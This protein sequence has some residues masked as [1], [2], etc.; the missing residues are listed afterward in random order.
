MEHP[1]SATGRGGNPAR[2]DEEVV[3]GR[4][5][6][7][8]NT[9]T[10]PSLESR[11]VFSQ[12]HSAYSASAQPDSC[13]RAGRLP[14]PLMLLQ[15]HHRA[16]PILQ[17]EVI[18]PPPLRC[19]SPRHPR[20]N[21]TSIFAVLRQVLCAVLLFYICFR[22]LL[23]PSDFVFPWRAINFP[24]SPRLVPILHFSHVAAVAVVNAHR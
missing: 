24:D 19:A 13:E 23:C 5:S 2:R 11:V 18:S 22:G 9:N 3:V 14:G 10:H 15:F 16:A 4:P 20:I 17:V 21:Y 7:I 12:V 1:G 8:A 6:G